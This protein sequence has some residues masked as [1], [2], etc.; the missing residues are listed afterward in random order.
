ML[1]MG[2]CG[3]VRDVCWFHA[4]YID[5]WLIC[6]LIIFLFD[7]IAI[8]LY[9]YFTIL[10]IGHIAH[11]RQGPQIPCREVTRWPF[12]HECDN[13]VLRSI[14]VNDHYEFRE[15]NFFN[16]LYICP[17]FF[18]W[19]CWIKLYENVNMLVPLITFQWLIFLTGYRTIISIIMLF[20]LCNTFHN[21]GVVV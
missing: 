12:R 17:G 5:I 11:W 4:Y 2:W 8:R 10:E 18:W 3:N 13:F 19:T 15:L 9:W 7:Y 6:Y 14:T 21:K 20:A 16:V 1:E